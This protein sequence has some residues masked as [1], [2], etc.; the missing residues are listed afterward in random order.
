MSET[1]QP[2]TS[3]A[4]RA[5]IAWGRITRGSE[6]GSSIEDRLADLVEATP[7]VSRFRVDVVH[8]DSDQAPAG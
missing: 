8:L 2:S 4:G 7:A 3:S 1:H 6:S 5:D